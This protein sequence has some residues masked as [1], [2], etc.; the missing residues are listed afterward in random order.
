VSFAS[1]LT[2][3]KASIADE[4]AGVVGTDANNR[5]RMLNL[6][7]LEASLGSIYGNSSC[8]GTVIES[9]VVQIALSIGMSRIANPLAACGWARHV[10]QRGAVIHNMAM[11]GRQKATP[12]YMYYQ[13]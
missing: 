4:C 8:I 13:A 1:L 3:S 5:P 10:R 2:L 9:I 7:Q 12:P 6:V 11:H